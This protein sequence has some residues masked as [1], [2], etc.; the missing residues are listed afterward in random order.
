MEAA[1]TAAEPSQADQAD[2]CWATAGDPW[3]ETLAEMALPQGGWASYTQVLARVYVS[4]SEFVTNLD[5][6]GQLYSGGV[7][8]S[9]KLTGGKDVS[10][11]SLLLDSLPCT[12]DVSWQ[13]HA[14]GAWL[15]YETYAAGTAEDASNTVIFPACYGMPQIIQLPTP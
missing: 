3:R 1:P 11:L 10:F 14:T 12:D 9:G 13:S 2:L 5:L 6:Y 8:H 4:C 7:F 15:D